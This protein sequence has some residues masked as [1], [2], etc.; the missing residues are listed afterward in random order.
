[1][2]D[3]QQAVQMVQQLVDMSDK[4][5]AAQQDLQKGAEQVGT[6]AVQKVAKTGFWKDEQQDVQSVETMADRMV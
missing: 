2:Q 5:L 6:S 4:A 3:R 1:M